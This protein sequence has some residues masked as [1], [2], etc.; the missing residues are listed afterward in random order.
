MTSPPLTFP[1]FRVILANERPLLAGLLVMMLARMIAIFVTPLSFGVDEAQYWLWGQD[2]AFGYYSKPPLIGWYL[3]MMDG[4]F[5][6]SA[7]AARFLAPVI[8]TIIALFL[9]RI[10]AAHHSQ[11]AGR[12]AALFWASLPL[13]SL[14][15]FV[16]STDTLLILP[17]V[18]A[19]GVFYQAETTGKAQHYLITGLIIGIGVLA[20]YAAIYFIIGALLHL[21]FISQASVK[22]SC[23]NLALILSGAVITASPNLLWNLANGG[24]TFAHLGENADLAQPLYS[25]ESALNFIL[26]QSAVAGPV[27]FVIL[28]AAL[29]RSRTLKQSAPLASYLCFAV[30]VLIIMVGQA[31]L[32]TANANWAATAWPSLCLIAGIALATIIPPIWGRLALSVNLFAALILVIALG[33]GDLLFLTPKSD[34]LRRLRGWETLAQDTKKLAETYQTPF[35]VADRRAEAALL[36][37]YLHDSGLAVKMLNEDG[38]AGNHYER[39]HA[40]SDAH[41]PALILSTPDATLPASLADATG[42]IG[43]SVAQISARKSR[44]K[45]FYILK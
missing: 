38:V 28:C 19:L 17:W 5:G 29:L 10:A 32:K 15:S 34:P 16:I 8:H 43:A 1:S 14:G 27:L 30:P 18:I 25:V 39:D 37:W 26:S 31:Y 40:L 22:A 3:G 2:L 7:V 6:S 35:I 11:K 24:V 41:R 21:I 12:W 45:T 42:P 23:R 20:K 33:L 9:Y 4:L 36:S 13:V 44:H